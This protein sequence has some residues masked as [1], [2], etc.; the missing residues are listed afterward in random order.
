[1][2]QSAL[3]QVAASFEAVPVRTC[4]GCGK[5]APRSEL[6]RIAAS[7]EGVLTV[8]PQAVRPGRGAWVHP[9]PACVERA[10]KRRAL[11]RALRLQEE[12]P[13]SLWSELDAAVSSRTS[14]TS[15]LE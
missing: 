13:E 11:K 10:R 12:P 9:D 5:R 1:M 14:P 3:N 6:F 8:D 4:T 7:R 2:S 15:V